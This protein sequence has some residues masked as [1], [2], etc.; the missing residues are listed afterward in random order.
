[1]SGPN[2]RVLVFP[3]DDSDDSQKAFEWVITNFFKDNDE[4]H[5]IHVIPRT[6]YAATYAVPAVDFT[7]GI[8][9][10]K[11][12]KAVR[13]AEEFIVKRFLS[14]IPINCQSTP[15]VHVI[16]SETDSESVGHIICQKAFDLNATAVVMGNHNKG[17]VRE[18]FMGSVSQYITHHCKRPV[19]I[20]RNI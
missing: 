18:F 16:K 2:Q 3:V 14:R 7:P 4:V 19:I 8:D 13:T 5:L 1:M 9:R 20:I 6:A 12:E 10:D 17:P 11:Y 15:I